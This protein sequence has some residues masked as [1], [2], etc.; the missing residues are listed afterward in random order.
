M[1]RRKSSAMQSIAT[2]CA[3]QDLDANQLQAKAKLLL[4]S[5]RHI[6]WS[7]LGSCQLGNDDS[8]CLCDEDIEKALDYLNSY[9]PTETKD[10]FERN[11]KELI[12]TRWMV[13]LVDSA[14]LQ[15]KEFPGTGEEYFEILSKFFLSKFKYSESDLLDILK[16][17]RS[18]YYDRK[19]EAVLVFGLALWGTVLPRIQILIDEAPLFDCPD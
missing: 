7:S 15:V 12:D 4:S 8:F 3:S 5:Y 14:M 17:E 6:C 11:L 18:R 9:S 13:E 19:K 1:C 10:I 2:M 16:M